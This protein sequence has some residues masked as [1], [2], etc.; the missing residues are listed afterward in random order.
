M[1][2]YPGGRN[3]AVRIGKHRNLIGSC[4]IAH[5][6][7]YETHLAMRLNAS[8][9]MKKSANPDSKSTSQANDAALD[10]T[11]SQSTDN[12]TGSQKQPGEATTNVDAVAT[13]GSEGELVQRGRPRKLYQ[14]LARVTGT[15][16][17]KGDDLVIVTESDKAELVVTKVVGKYTAIRLLKLPDNRRQGTFSLYPEMN[18]F[19]VVTFMTEV[20]DGQEV[21]APPNNQMFVSG[22]LASVEADGFYINIDRNKR[23][24]KAKR[25][26]EMP[27]KIDGHAARANWKIGQWLGLILHREGTRWMWRGETKEVLRAAP[28]RKT[29]SEKTD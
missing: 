6:H 22:K 12:D 26:I 2:S 5:L 9:T 4:L 19:R 21:E 11:V 27:L 16:Q 8:N 29:D 15:L 28:W 17:V 20:S 1:L 18:G 25:L 3:R 23:T 10:K 13:E 7:S 24:I 14:A